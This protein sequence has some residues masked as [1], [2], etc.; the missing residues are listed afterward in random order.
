MKESKLS[1]RL[2]EKTT[3]IV[4]IL[5]LCMLFS[6]PFFDRETYTDYETSFEIGLRTMISVYDQFGSSSAY[7]Q[8]I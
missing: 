6:T 2:S 5:T 3:K 8:E 7:F 4:I 1:K